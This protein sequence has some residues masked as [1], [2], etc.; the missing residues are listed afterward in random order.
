MLRVRLIDRTGWIDPVLQR[1]WAALAVEA[2]EPNPF[3]EGWF[4]APSLD[5]PGLRAQ[6]A[7]VLLGDDLVGVLPLVRS[8]TYYGY[9]IPNLSGWVHD[10]AFCGAP[11]V[12]RGFEAAFWQKLLAWADGEA[13]A[14]LFLHL[15]LLPGD[16]PLHAALRAVLTEQGRPA[17]VVHR[18]E[19]ALLASDLAP[20]AYFDGSM[21]GKKRKELRRQHARLAELGELAFERREDEAGVAA[22]AD[23]FLALELGG[24][25]GREGSA[26]ACDPAN[27][28]L[29]RQV[30]AGAAEA[31]K[32]E[33]LTLTVDGQPIAMLAN[34]L[35]PPG[36]YSFKT[37]YDERFARFSPGVLLQRENLALLA[38]PDIA[39][40]DSCAAA[41]HPM[42]ERIWREKREMVHVSVAIGGKMRRT[43]AAAILRA[44]TG[45][46]PKGI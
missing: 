42:I 15:P 12:R 26:L 14:A 4:L 28:V 38:R 3:C 20:N 22:W 10:N 46:W 23:A 17:A 9:P 5:L 34:F 37:A 18:S 45:A 31:G 29:F 35:T 2:A 21:S 11:L 32:L 1:Q 27:A 36:A 25:K 30:I 7:L 41:D 19:R 44:E 16:G 24:W 13:G 40:T 39:W 8:A 33:R 6:L 43:L